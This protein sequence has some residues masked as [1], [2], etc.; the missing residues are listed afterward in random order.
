MTAESSGPITDVRDDDLK[1]VTRTLVSQPDLSAD[2]VDRFFGQIQALA[3]DRARRNWPSEAAETMALFIRTDYTRPAG[4]DVNDKK[5]AAD[6]IGTDEP[7]LGRMFVLDTNASQGW[8]I[9]LPHSEPGELIEWL[10]KSQFAGCQAVILY[11]QTLLLIDRANGASG[12]MTRKEP[13]RDTFPSVTKPSLIEALDLF[14]MREVLTPKGCP[15]GVW[16]P[17][18]AHMYYAGPSPETSIQAR[19]K[20][21]LNGWFRGLLRAEVEDSTEIGRIDIRLLTPTG[22]T[23]GLSYWGIIELKVVKSFR[24]SKTGGAPVKV[25]PIQNARDVAKGIQQAHAFG[26]NRGCACTVLQIFDMRKDKVADP[27]THKEVISVLP[28]CVP[29][30]E[31]RLTPIFGSAQDARDAGIIPPP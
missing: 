1:A 4:K 20:T 26:K 28:S 24:H 19:L 2:K 29:H 23:G 21:F 13:I 7:L 27:R 9:A 11:R 5:P 17:S 18:F 22:P 10:T 31:M 25:A 14:Q 3:E 15:E 30:P 8:S 12:G 16:Q 6:M